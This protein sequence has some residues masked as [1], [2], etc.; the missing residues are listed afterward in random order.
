MFKN[1]LQNRKNQAIRQKSG[2]F[3][4]VQSDKYLSSLQKELSKQI[5]ARFVRTFFDLFIAMLT[6]RNRAMGLLLTE[7][8]GFIAGFSS[9]PAGTKRISRLL[10]CKKWSHHLIDD[11]F[12]NRGKQRMLKLKEEEKKRPL[13]LWDD[14]RIE[15]PESWFLEGLCSVFSSKGQRLTKIKKG[16]Y[17]PPTSR[18]CVPGYKWTGITLSALGEIPSV[19]H[20][21]WWTTRGRHKEHGTNI[22][23]KM[24][25]KI[26]GQIGSMALHVFDR[27]YANANMLEWLINFQQDFLIR[28][29]NNHLFINEKGEVKKIHLIARSYKGK[30]SRFIWDKQRKKMKHV[31]VAWA[32]V[33]HPEFPDN[34]LYLVIIRD[35]NNYNSPMY[36]LTSLPIEAKSQAWE[37]CYT[38]MHRWEIEQSFRCCKSEL[39]MESPRLWWFENTLK[40]LA[41]LTL[42]YDFLLRMLCNWKPWTNQLLANWCHR[43]GNR[44]RQAA[45]PIY[46]LRAAISMALLALFFEKLFEQRGWFD[47]AT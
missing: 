23:Y 5:D 8:G 26:H 31:S 46:R 4:L 20:M 2:E 19:F 38:Y 14:S 37:M 10:R 40:L 18:I 44:Y 3:L 35:K 28:W 9:A 7:L 42:V 22:I 13:L 27:G 24:L 21:A 29:K 47:G 39:A 32:P 15:K 1:I 43:T 11:F 45:I 12:F 6:F 30:S 33:W 25:K 36:L 41:V 17:N 34:Q 16:Y